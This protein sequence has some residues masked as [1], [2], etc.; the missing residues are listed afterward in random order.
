MF[1]DEEPV[2]AYSEAI[3]MLAQG[4]MPFIIPLE[5]ELHVVS[6]VPTSR[7]V[8]AN[9]IDDREWVR[10]RFMT[11]TAVAVREHTAHQPS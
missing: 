11:Q 9:M 3:R 4:A 10:L 8:L 2:D 5:D 1:D 6:I 7:A